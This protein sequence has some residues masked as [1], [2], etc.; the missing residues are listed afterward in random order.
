MLITGKKSLVLNSKTTTLFFLARLML[1][2]NPKIISLS[3]SLSQICDTLFRL[4]TP[5]RN[6]LRKNARRNNSSQSWSQPGKGKRKEIKRTRSGDIQMEICIMKM[7]QPI[8]TPKTNK[9][10]KNSL[11]MSYDLRILP[12]EM[13]QIVI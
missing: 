9:W 8:S 12:Y 2:I 10:S 6:C 3:L 1:A 5:Y 11:T 13:S 4:S 7:Y